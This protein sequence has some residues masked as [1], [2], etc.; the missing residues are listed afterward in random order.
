MDR[1]GQVFAQI[2]YAS[3]AR[4]IS[5]GL[6]ILRGFGLAHFLGPAAFGLWSSM[7][8]VLQFGGYSQFGARSGMLQ[9]AT[10]SEAAGQI[11]DAIRLR[12]TAAAVNLAGAIAVGAAIAWIVM[13][14]GLGIASRGLWLGLAGLIVA[15]NM[16]AYLQVNLRSQ[17]R[18]GLCSSLSILMAALSTGLGVLGAYWQGLPGFLAALGLSYLLTFAIAFPL[19]SRYPNPSINWADVSRLLRIGM[20]IMMSDL[21]KVLMWNVDKIMIWMLMGKHSLGIY[22]LQ[23]TITNGIM[24]LPAGVADVFYPHVV[25]EIG[26]S[27]S[28]GTAA[29]YLT[30]GV[31]LLS[32]SMCPMLAVI[33][34]CFHLPIRWLLPAYQETVAPGQVLVLATFFPVAGTIAGSV[35]LALGGQRTQLVASA[36]AVVVAVIC[37]GAAILSGGGY[38]AIALGAAAG[39]LA[40]ASISIGAAIV[41]AQLSVPERV[42]FLGRLVAAFVLV[43]VAVAGAT[44]AI[45]DSPDSLLQDCLFTTVRC[46]IALAILSPFIVSTLRA[47]R[48]YA[49]SRHEGAAGDESA[50]HA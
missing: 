1:R 43:V 31:E 35:L 39:L 23:S 13:L 46:A 40:R 24:L 4:Y 20:P 16:W 21:L 3:A 18:Y 47:R 5:L 50:D 6:R 33:F 7:R 48:R 15:D 2:S 25:S 45:P 11:A 38:V 10:A 17:R 9:Q 37:V 12:G 49:G 30:Q 14:P 42:Q 19:G 8:I 28:A 36:I 44:W 22:A 32:R 29:R 41:R 27:K 34:L 26:R